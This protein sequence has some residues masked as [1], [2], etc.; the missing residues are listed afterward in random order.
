MTKLVLI[1]VLLSQIAQAMPN[2]IEASCLGHAQPILSDYSS[3][4]APE[5]PNAELS[6]KDIAKIIPTNMPATENPKDIVNQIGDRVVQNWLSSDAVKSSAMGRTASTVESAM[7][8]EVVVPKT[9]TEGV[10]HRFSFQYLILQALTKFEYKGWL[11]ATVNYN[12]KAA[13]TGIEVNEK[14]WNNKDVYLNHTITSAEGS[15]SMGI[16][17]GW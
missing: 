15:S 10:E 4:H 9:K 6:S 5:N 16:R 2:S 1:L 8:T 3:I 12:A 17:W 14:I 7:K 11:N 13:Q